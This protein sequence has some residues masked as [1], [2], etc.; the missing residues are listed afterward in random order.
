[1]SIV[2]IRVEV[3]QLI[4][5]SEGLALANRKQHTRLDAV[6]PR[7]RLKIGPEQVPN[8]ATFGR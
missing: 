6:M 5:R 8:T 2:L 7:R 3:G 4:L 1:M